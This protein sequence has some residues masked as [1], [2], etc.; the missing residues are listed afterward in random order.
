MDDY[1][2]GLACSNL[3]IMH[4]THHEL[5]AEH[6]QSLGEQQ[7]QYFVCYVPF[8]GRV[9][10]LDSSAAGPVVLGC[11]E[12]QQDWVRVAEKEVLRKIRLFQLNEQS[13]TLMALGRDRRQ[14]LLQQVDCQV[15][16]I[17]NLIQQARLINSTE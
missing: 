7:Q 10:E 3:D 1:M 2:K 8:K 11:L 5:S 4:E 15:G 12:T 6:D 14:G 16:V 9:Y 13:F 17:W